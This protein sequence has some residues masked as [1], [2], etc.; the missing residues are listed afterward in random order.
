M[1]GRRS[2]G[3]GEGIRARDR[4]RPRAQIPHS[5][6]PFNACHA[7]YKEVASSVRLLTVPG[8]GA[9]GYFLGG[10]VPPGTPNWHPV[11]KKIPLKLIPRS[12]IRPKT[13]TPF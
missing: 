7:G 13:D 6:S 2:K 1:R 8:G 4:A 12:R 5:P 11:L 3:K 10:Y 9:L